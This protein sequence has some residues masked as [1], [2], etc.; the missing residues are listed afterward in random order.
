IFTFR[1]FFGGKFFKR[2]CFGRWN[3]LNEADKL[4]CVSH[5]SQTHFAVSRLFPCLSI[6]LVQTSLKEKRS[7]GNAVS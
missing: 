4:L 2:F 3:R 6:K 1:D 5:I 7:G